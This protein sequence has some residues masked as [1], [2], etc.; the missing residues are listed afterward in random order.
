MNFMFIFTGIST[1]QSLEI[2]KKAKKDI[3][4]HHSAFDEEG[5][6]EFITL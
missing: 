4:F 2:E 6:C 3:M 1:G 5:T